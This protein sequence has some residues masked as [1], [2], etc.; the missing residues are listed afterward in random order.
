MTD[1]NDKKE[2][3]H[4]IHYSVDDEPEFTSEKVLTPVQIMSSAGIDPQTNYLEQ[5]VHG[6]E[7]VSYK[8]N[9]DTK[10]EMKNGMRFITKPTGPMPVS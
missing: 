6:H 4:R 7:F 3:E 9:P 2:H 1:D 5:I 10:I 8:D